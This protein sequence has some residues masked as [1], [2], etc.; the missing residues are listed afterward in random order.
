MA[1]K[2]R[3]IEEEQPTDSELDTQEFQ[4]R[5]LEY[6]QAIDWKIWEMAKIFQQFAEE[7][8]YN[9]ELPK[10]SDDDNSQSD[11]DD[12]IE[13]QPNRKTSKVKPVI[14]DEDE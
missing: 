8:G 3:V 4:K 5:M 6:M 14:V 11:V 13:E 2:I 12:V 10:T 1:K 9:S 7:H